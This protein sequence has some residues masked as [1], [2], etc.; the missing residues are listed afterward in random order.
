[1]ENLFEHVDKNGGTFATA[2][3]LFKL[4]ITVIQVLHHDDDITVRCGSSGNTW[5]S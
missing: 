3:E 2:G 4:I 1:M 5:D